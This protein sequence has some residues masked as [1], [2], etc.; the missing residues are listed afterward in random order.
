MDTATFTVNAIGH[1]RAG[2]DG[3]YLD[4]APEYRPA[5]K[6]LDGFGHINVLWW[7]HPY[8]HAPAILG[9][10]ATR[11]PVRPNPIALT[12]VAVTHIDHEQ[13]RIYIPYTD[14]EDGSPILDIKPYHPCEDRIRDVKLPEWCAHW[15]QWY[16]DSAD[17]DWAAE[18]VNAR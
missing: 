2:E 1:I 12:T 5:L 7:L 6:G 18:F 10:F 14:A 13:G 17:F 16:E 11:A 8:K 9:I 3:F 4:I 15:P